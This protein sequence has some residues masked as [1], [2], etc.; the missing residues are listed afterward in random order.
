MGRMAGAWDAAK[1]VWRRYGQ[2]QGSLMAAALSFFTLLSLIPLLAMAV[3]V[4]AFILSDEGARR[5]TLHTIGTLL[6]T[7]AKD[8]NNLVQGLVEGRARA[9][10]LALAGLLWTSSQLFTNLESALGAVWDVQERRGWL[11][12]HLTALGV[13]LLT[14][15]MLVVSAGATAVLAL[16][17]GMR[18]TMFGIHP[19][20]LPY[21]WDVL[22]HGIGLIA[23]VGLFLVIYKLTPPVEVHWKPALVGAVFAGI[24]F[25]AA[26][27][28]FGWYLAHFGHYN[29]VYGSLGSLII[30]VTW[31][32]YSATILVLG[33]EVTDL[34]ADRTGSRAV[35]PARLRDRG[36]EGTEGD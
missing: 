2:D 4:L 34:Y 3:S 7:Q 36:A 27:Q 30:L 15:L 33:A 17:R 13:M 14:G 16:I 19:G 24:A 29:A 25:E 1:E 11:R 31:V 21:F 32:Y 6:P 10:G 35:E 26:K 28:L 20:D 5:Q 18:L 8:I 12:S 22:G 23:S 9:G